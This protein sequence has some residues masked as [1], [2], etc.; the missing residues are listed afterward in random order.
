M[1]TYDQWRANYAHETVGAVARMEQL[2]PDPLFQSGVLGRGH[3]CFVCGQREAVT[4]LRTATNPEAVV[5]LCSHC[6]SDWNCYGY[7]ILKKIQPM[8]L[9]WQ[10]TKWFAWKP[11]Q[12]NVVW[13]DLR[14]LQKWQGKVSRLK[15]QNKSPSG[16]SKTRSKTQ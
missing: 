6:S 5:P 9:I 12:R 8:T 13:S 3:L 7:H 2:T 14:H 16:S 15:Q 11:W 10:L 1:T 4:S